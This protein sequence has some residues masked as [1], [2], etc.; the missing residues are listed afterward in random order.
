MQ[1]IAM[2]Q[3]LMRPAKESFSSL[4]MPL[5]MIHWRPNIEAD[6]FLK[7]KTTEIIQECANSRPFRERYLFHFQ[8]L[9]VY[10]HVQNRMSVDAKELY[11]RILYHLLEF[12]KDSLLANFSSVKMLGGF[13]NSIFAN[14]PDLAKRDDEV[15]KEFLVKALQFHKYVTENNCSE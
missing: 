9:K 3:I 10:S 5:L 15:L 11:F 1:S 7:E 2:L 14:L 13:F 8:I 12:P 6:F 4:S